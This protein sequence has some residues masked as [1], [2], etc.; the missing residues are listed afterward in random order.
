MSTLATLEIPEISQISHPRDLALG[1][2]KTLEPLLLSPL[3]SSAVSSAQAIVLLSLLSLAPV[4]L[5]LRFVLLLRS[6]RVVRI[7]GK[8]RYVG[9]HERPRRKGRSILVVF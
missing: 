5:S 4:G 3:I 8:L 2:P 6:C 1:G 7:F 9:T